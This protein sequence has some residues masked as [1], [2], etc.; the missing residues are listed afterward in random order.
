ME[1]CRQALLLAAMIAT[2]ILLVGLLSSVITGV[3]Q[4]LFQVQDQT[5]SF[6]PKLLACS[7]VLLVG[8]PW[9]FQRLI[10]FS[11]SMFSGGSF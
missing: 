6:V 2:P 3:M 4:T 11:R 7:V 5:I 1:L 9:M 8:L 10:E